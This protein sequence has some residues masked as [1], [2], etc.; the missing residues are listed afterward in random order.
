MYKSRLIGKNSHAVRQGE[1]I[2]YLPFPVCL[3][4]EVN[5]RNSESIELVLKKRRGL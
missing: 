4:V 1:F 2:N 5:K 3:S